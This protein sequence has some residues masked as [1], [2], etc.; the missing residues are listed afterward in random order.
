MKDT[1]QF[2]W[3]SFNV[4]PSYSYVISLKRSADDI[5]LDFKKQERTDTRRALGNDNLKVKKGSLEEILAINKLVIER[6]KAQ[7][8][9]FGLNEY[10]LRNLYLNFH[11]NIES[12]VL[13]H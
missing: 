1:R 9:N 13:Y 8:R 7:E 4:K 3:N 6:Y 10:H 12:L 2:K 5:L 11:K